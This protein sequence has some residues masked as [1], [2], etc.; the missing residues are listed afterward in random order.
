MTNQENYILK[1]AN[2][3]FEEAFLANNY[4]QI[5]IQIHE[6]YK[7]FQVQLDEYSGFFLYAYTALTYAAAMETAKLFDEDKKTISVYKLQNHFSEYIHSQNEMNLDMLK[8]SEYNHT[9]S[10]K[11]IIFY[12]KNYPDI[13]KLIEDKQRNCNYISTKDIVR[14]QLSITEY[15][16][17][18]KYKRKMLQ[19]IINNLHDHRNMVF[20]HSDERFEVSTIDEKLPLMIKDLL[21]L[22]QYSLDI[23]NFVIT[24]FT[25][26]TKS[27]RISNIDDI[28]RLLKNIKDFSYYEYLSQEFILKEQPT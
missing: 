8:Q 18:M 12:R 14:I 1:L 10:E 21:P 25:G 28:Q 16:K 15:L 26:V 9:F 3:V 27:E 7:Q 23:S 17:V 11:E 13:S 6:N 19:P 5:I 22:I 24:F 2:E 4:Y 20:A